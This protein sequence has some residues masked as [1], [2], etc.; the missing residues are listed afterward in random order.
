MNNYFATSRHHELHANTPPCRHGIAAPSHAGWFATPVLSYR[1]EESLRR[2]ACHACL[3][4]QRRYLRTADI[5][6]H[7][8]ADGQS[9]RFLSRVRMPLENQMENVTPRHRPESAAMLN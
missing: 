3:P 8:M 6:H 5:C 7:A 1:T 9:G 2:H 4:K